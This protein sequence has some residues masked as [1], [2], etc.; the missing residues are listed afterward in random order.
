[1]E[2]PIPIYVALWQHP[3]IGMRIPRAHAAWRLSG[4]LISSLMA[5]EFMRPIRGCNASLTAKSDHHQ[6]L[7]ALAGKLLQAHFATEQHAARLGNHE[8][9]FFA[10]PWFHQRGAE[11]IV[12][13]DWLIA[14]HA[15]PSCNVR[16]LFSR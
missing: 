4:H 3:V 10:D 12:S 8:S 7:D 5:L 1:M 13:A 9:C 2:R 15:L 14:A 16:C 6:L 11:E